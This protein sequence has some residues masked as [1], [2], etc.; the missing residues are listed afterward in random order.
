MQSYTQELGETF[1]IKCL[2]TWALK[3]DEKQRASASAAPRV[4]HSKSRENMGSR[5]SLYVLFCFFQRIEGRTFKYTQIAYASQCH[6]PVDSQKLYETGFFQV[7]YILPI[8]R[9]RMETG[10]LQIFDIGGNVAKDIPVW[11]TAIL[12]LCTKSTMWQLAISED[13]RRGKRSSICQFK[14]NFLFQ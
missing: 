14:D 5:Y 3:K 10:Y 13:I 12:P 9:I 7:G 8:Y 1:A 6:T 4:A 11:T 2:Q